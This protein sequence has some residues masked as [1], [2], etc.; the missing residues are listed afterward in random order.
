MSG[1]L[2]IHA[3]LVWFLY[4]IFLIITELFFEVNWSVFIQRNINLHYSKQGAIVA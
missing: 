2:T 4:H 3:P 1:L